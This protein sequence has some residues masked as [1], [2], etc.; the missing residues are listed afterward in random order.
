MIIV[1]KGKAK[2]IVAQSISYA[3]PG[4]LIA[5]ATSTIGIKPCGGCKGRQQRLNQWWFDL[6]DKLTI[7]M[8]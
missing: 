4:D 7:A 8:K 1:I 2:Q 5:K 3:R 6:T